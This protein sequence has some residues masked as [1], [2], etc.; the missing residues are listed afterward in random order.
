MQRKTFK[1]ALSAHAS[2]AIDGSEY[3]AIIEA[4][5][6]CAYMIGKTYDWRDFLSVA[7]D[8]YDDKASILLDHIAYSLGMSWWSAEWSLEQKKR[9]PELLAARAVYGTQEYLDVLMDVA[10]W[11]AYEVHGKDIWIGDVSTKTERERL[12]EMLTTSFPVGV[13]DSVIEYP[14]T[15]YWSMDTGG[16]GYIPSAINAIQARTASS[17]PSYMQQ[18]KKGSLAVRHTDTIIGDRAAASYLMQKKAALSAYSTQIVMGQ[19][20]T[21]DI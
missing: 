8:K 12:L 6:P 20:I 19:N 11:V 14:A 18:T 3:E 7:A 21:K 16:A 17:A 4:L 9:L 15:L 10:G 1:I 2:S 13:W 5:E